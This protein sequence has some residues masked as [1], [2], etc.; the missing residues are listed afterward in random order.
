M[1]PLETGPA[2]PGDNASAAHVSA[3]Q[4]GIVPVASALLPSLGVEPR[5]ASYGMLWVL[6]G[7]FM[8]CS[9]ASGSLNVSLLVSRMSQYGYGTSM[10]WRIYSAVASVVSLV[11]LSC[12]MVVLLSN[13]ILFERRS[14]WLAWRC[15]G[16]T[17]AGAAP[18]RSSLPI[19]APLLVYGGLQVIWSGFACEDSPNDLRWGLVLLLHGIFSMVAGLAAEDVRRL[20]QRLAVAGQA[21]SG[22]TRGTE[23]PRGDAQAF[24]SATAGKWL[25]R[26]LVVI[27]FG[28]LVK[29]C[30]Y[31]FLMSSY[32]GRLG[33]ELW[34]Y[35]L[36]TSGSYALAVTLVVLSRDWAKATLQWEN[37]RK[38]IS[39]LPSDK[40]TDNRACLL[41]VLSVSVLGLLGI[42][43]VW[44][45][46]FNLFEVAYFAC[47]LSSEV[48]V[49]VAMGVAK[50][51]TRQWVLATQSV[52]GGSSQQKM[53]SRLLCVFVLAPLGVRVAFEAWGN[54]FGISSGGLG[55]F[56]W[57]LATNILPAIFHSAWLI[58]I[59]F[60]IARA[61][62]NLESCEPE[63][64]TNG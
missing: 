51:H 27:L 10:D 30:A 49:L 62:L 29:D 22:R 3:E 38:S 9:L 48:L 19:M 53:P 44:S 7:V 40:T 26:I 34:D 11:F 8:L 56:A 14:T 15:G 42:A 12:W 37:V 50:W 54:W 17:D 25:P 55:F 39:R 57:W 43:R 60:D 41:V 52:C 24:T 1:P 28:L 6:A 64:E 13:A 59:G 32:K 45:V 4:P 61:R 2:S 58:L 33:N 5:H 20:L 18:A 36:Y 31:V 35:L 47:A 63:G 21:L 23:M 46:T 16:L